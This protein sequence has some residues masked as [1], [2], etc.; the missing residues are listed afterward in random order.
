M[1]VPEGFSVR[2]V[3]DLT[4]LHRSLVIGAEGK[5]VAPKGRSA[6]NT[7]FV[8]VEFQLGGVKLDLDVRRV[9][10]E[11]IDPRWI[12]LLSREI[13]DREEALRNNVKTATVYTTPRGGFVEL[14][15]EYNNGRADDCWKVKS[16]A[17]GVLA[18]LERRGLL[19]EAKAT[20]RG[21][22]P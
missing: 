14:V 12:D 15:V 9:N 17:R 3:S 13:K 16:E 18:D 5:V 2:V 10:L 21:K 22:K 6:I 4:T 8:R 7:S 19:E 1:L 11:V 20:S